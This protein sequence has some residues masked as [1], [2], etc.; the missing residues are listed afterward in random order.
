MATTQLR[1][2]GDPWQPRDARRVQGDASSDRG[3]C[4][5]EFRLE[6]IRN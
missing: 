1:E 4:Q 3:W 6:L 2:R 5:R